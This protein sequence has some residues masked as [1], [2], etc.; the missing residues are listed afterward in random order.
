MEHDIVFCITRPGDTRQRAAG[1]AG[2]AAAV[3]TRAAQVCWLPCRT[4]T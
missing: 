2:A 3:A 4:A 1:A